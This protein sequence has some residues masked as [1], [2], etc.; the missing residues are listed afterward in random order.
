MSQ[1]QKIIHRVIYELNKKAQILASQARTNGDDVL[2]SAYESISTVYSLK[3]TDQPS[4]GPYPP[5]MLL[6][7]LHMILLI[8]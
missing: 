4:A 2:A 1:A 3:N 6:L 5:V 8:I 7:R